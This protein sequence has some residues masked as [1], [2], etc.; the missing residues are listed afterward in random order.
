MGYYVM[1]LDRKDNQKMNDYLPK[2][3]KELKDQ[4]DLLDVMDNVIKSYFKGFNDEQKQ[5]VRDL[6]ATLKG[7]N[8][9]QPDWSNTNYLK[10][11]IEVI[12]L[13]G[14]AQ[15]HIMGLRQGQEIALSGINSIMEK[16][17][18]DFKK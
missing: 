1:V 3:A 2:T 13:R 7:E 11:I 6:L 4:N 10:S 8:L 14:C 16:N 5:I 15:G 18:G 12:Y 9:N 17:I